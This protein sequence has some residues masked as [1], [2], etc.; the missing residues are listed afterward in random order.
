[1]CREGEGSVRACPLLFL[2]DHSSMYVSSCA[3][4]RLHHGNARSESAASHPRVIVVVLQVREKYSHL[5]KPMPSA[6]HLLDVVRG[7][8][9]CAS[10]AEME[11]SFHKVCEHMEVLRAKNS[12]ADTHVEFGFRQVRI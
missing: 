8:V 10:V 6:A 3:L 9:G 12:F 1:M 7:I 4:L 5:D 2:S 11:E